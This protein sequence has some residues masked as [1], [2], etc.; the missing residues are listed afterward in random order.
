[1]H[2]MFEARDE[3]DLEI[4]MAILRG[5]THIDNDEDERSARVGTYRGTRDAR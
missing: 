4:A 2:S 3:T 5:G 1:M